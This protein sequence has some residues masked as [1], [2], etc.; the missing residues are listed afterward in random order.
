MLLDVLLGLVE[1]LLLLGLVV[2]P[3]RLVVL[4]PVLPLW[5]LLELL[6]Q[7]SSSSPVSCGPCSSPSQVCVDSLS[8]SLVLPVPQ[9]SPFS[10]H[11]LLEPVPPL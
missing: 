11:V 4:E 8:V 3:L 7:L 9:S 2:L 10:S 1:E 6:E 5:V